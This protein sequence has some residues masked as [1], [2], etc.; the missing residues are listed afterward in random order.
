MRKGKSDVPGNGDGEPICK[1]VETT[2]ELIIAPKNA[3]GRL[4]ALSEYGSAG[5]T[6]TYNPSV[7]SQERTVSTVINYNQPFR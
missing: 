5:K 3:K 4:S 7:N 2:P 1:P 6:R